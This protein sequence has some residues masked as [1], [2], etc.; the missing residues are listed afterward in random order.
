[1]RQMSILDKLWLIRLARQ[2]VWAIVWA[3]SSTYPGVNAADLA[4]K[5]VDRV[6]IQA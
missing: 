2:M 5:A 1:M 4:D 6:D 3:L